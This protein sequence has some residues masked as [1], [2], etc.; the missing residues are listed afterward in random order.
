MKGLSS[1]FLSTLLIQATNIGTGILAARLLHPQG[2][3][4]LAV[5]LVWPS[6]L[7]A[8]SILGLNDAVA[9]YVAQPGASTKNIYATS[10][11]MAAAIGTLL[12]GV[13]LFLIPHLISTQRPIVIRLSLL[14][15]L[16]LIPLN[17]WTMING[18]IFLGKQRLTEYN[19]LRT[20]V[21]V[22]Y[23][24]G[25]A[26]CYVIRTASLAGFTL[27]YLGGIAL[28]LA[29]GLLWLIKRQWFAFTPDFRLARPLLSYG[30]K[31]HVGSLASLLNWRFD[32]MVMSVFI[33]PKMLGLYV[34]AVSTSGGVALLTTAVSIVTFSKLA[35]TLEEPLR[36]EAFA[37][38]IRL[39]AALS[40]CSAVFFV[41]AAPLIIRFFFGI[42]FMEAVRA[43]QILSIA[44]IFLGC[45]WV[46]MAGFRAYGLPF[47]AS[48]SE[49]M[50][51]AATGLGLW[52][53]LP[54]YGILGAAWAS[55][56][57][58]LVSFIY[59]LFILKSR[60]GHSPFRVLIPNRE[61]WR[62]GLSMIQDFS[63]RFS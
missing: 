22:G 19:I 57:A 24:A 63:T 26:I 55:L 4:E 14:S 31:V 62:R 51:L 12:I 1:S 8:L 17:S 46:M 33:A 7:A 42:A 47:V 35:N 53:L 45:N 11:W 58:Y 18:A 38:F 6:L 50:S 15:L 40:V 56:L 2:R 49:L 39:A 21:N 5:I 13:G 32:Q 20:L 54:R 28:I 59:Y 60:L 30:V 52:I 3:G 10:V 29:L 34:V 23:L 9:Y 61:D 43:T 41:A 44:T 27:S 48:Q 37:R 25:I 36:R 16:L